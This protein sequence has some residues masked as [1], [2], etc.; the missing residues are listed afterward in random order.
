MS[1]N[2][3]KPCV[4]DLTAYVKLNTNPLLIPSGAN[5]AGWGYLIPFLNIKVPELLKNF[6]YDK[7]PKVPRNLSEKEL[8]V[9]INR[10]YGMQITKDLVNEFNNEF[11]I[12]VN[13][14][15]DVWAPS[16]LQN[17]FNDI[18]GDFYNLERRT[19]YKK[20]VAEFRFLERFPNGLIILKDIED[21]QTYHNYTSFKCPSE[22]IIDRIIGTQ[23]LQLVYPSRSHF[24]IEDSEARDVYGKPLGKLRKDNIV[25]ARPLYKSG[26]IGMLY[27]NQRYVVSAQ[28]VD[29]AIFEVESGKTPRIIPE[30][31]GETGILTIP[32]Q[33]YTPYD[34]SIHDVDLQGKNKSKFPLATLPDAWE[35]A[36]QEPVVYK[37][38][39]AINKKIKDE[40][41]KAEKLRTSSKIKEYINAPKEVESNL[42][43]RSE[44]VKKAIEEQARNTSTGPSGKITR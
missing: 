10:E 18:K 4:N 20:N 13:D 3:T 19:I 43:R 34:P 8:S 9:A 16:K 6:P 7:Y 42:K 11:I 31:L 14:K 2:Y 38:P 37:D 15:Y 21:A 40:K 1:T 26:L 39:T 30:Q 24:Y 22:V 28:N 35:L 27:G 44:A 32:F 29:S 12:Q 25:S 41:L 5:I 33:N 36:G 17:D 23:T